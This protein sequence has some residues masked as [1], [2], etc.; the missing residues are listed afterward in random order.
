MGIVGLAGV[1]DQQNS[2]IVFLPANWLAVVGLLM[3]ASW[4][5]NAAAE[6]LTFDSNG[7]RLHG[8]I[9]RPQ[10]RGP[11]LAVIF[12][13]GSEKDPEPSAHLT[14]PVSM[15]S[16]ATCSLH[17]SVTITVRRRAR[18]SKTFKGRFSKMVSIG[19][20]NSGKL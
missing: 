7:F 20:H 2:P 11:S 16:R 1:P 19:P 9:M 3:G 4:V 10:G 14:W 5:S 8:C 17:S 12:N 18:T 6:Q 15:S 13:H